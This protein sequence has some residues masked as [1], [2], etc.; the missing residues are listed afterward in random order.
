LKGRLYEIYNYKREANEGDT[1]TTQDFNKKELAK[2]SLETN[3]NPNHRWDC[4]HPTE[5]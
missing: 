4:S 5:V 2:F 3:L 1:K